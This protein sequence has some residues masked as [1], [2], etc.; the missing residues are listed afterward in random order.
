MKQIKVI[1][2]FLVIAFA[3]VPAH[4]DYNA[5]VTDKVKAAIL[6]K[7]CDIPSG[8]GGMAD[9]E[10]SCKK[11][12]AIEVWNDKSIAAADK[13]GVTDNKKRKAHGDSQE[14]IMAEAKRCGINATREGD[15]ITVT[16]GASR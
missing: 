4:A 1:W 7:S 3:T 13:P 9:G 16:D 14:L 11:V 12:L 15:T 10:L 8:L 5:C 2:S 6:A